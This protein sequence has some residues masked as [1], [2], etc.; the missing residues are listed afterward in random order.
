M[1]FTFFRADGETPASQINVSFV[2]SFIDSCLQH[3]EEFVIAMFPL[4]E[5]PVCHEKYAHWHDRRGK[6][7]CKN[8]VVCCNKLQVSFSCSALK[9]ALMQLATAGYRMKTCICRRGRQSGGNQ[10]V[11]SGMYH[12]K[13]TRGGGL[14]GDNCNFHSWAHKL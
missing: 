1:D 2:C 8:G 14:M 3:M 9:A 12:C 7:Y 10:R 5:L 13:K 4:A 11:F 6:M